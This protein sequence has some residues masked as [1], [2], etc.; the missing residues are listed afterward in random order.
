M[1]EPQTE[2]EPLWTFRG[3]DL[4]TSDFNTA[5]VHF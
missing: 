2:P 4:K 1:N 3:R 5:L